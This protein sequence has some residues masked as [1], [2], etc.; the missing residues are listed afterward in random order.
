IIDKY[1]Q[2]SGKYLEQSKCIDCSPAIGICEIVYYKYT[3]KRKATTTAIQIG[4][5]EGKKYDVEVVV[6]VTAGGNGKKETK[7][8]VSTQ[9]SE[10]ETNVPELNAASDY[11]IEY[12]CPIECII[13]PTIP[14]LCPLQCRMQQSQAIPQPIPDLPQLTT[15][16]TKVP[17]QSGEKRRVQD[18]L[19]TLDINC[20]KKYLTKELKKAKLTLEEAMKKCVNRCSTTKT[21]QR[22]VYSAS[23][24]EFVPPIELGEPEEQEEQEQTEESEQQGTQQDSIA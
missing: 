6:R 23:T 22:E 18:D 1:L 11:H 24:E 16:P 13:L 15:D 8:D 7:K 9:P 21:H 3:L 19:K 14:R 10:P 2:Q 5:S 4:T 12:P 20:Y 17:A